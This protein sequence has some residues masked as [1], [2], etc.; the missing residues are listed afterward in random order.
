MRKEPIAFFSERVMGCWHR[1]PREVVESLSLE[2][3]KKCGDVALRDMVSGHGGGGLRLDYMILEV[4]S[5][6]NDS[7]NPTW[8]RDSEH[9]QHHFQEQ[10]VQS[11]TLQV[12]SG[13]QLQF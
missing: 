9:T 1:L 12:S 13:C 8:L 10:D 4:F 5:N 11:Y 2:V 3:F 6:F 7:M